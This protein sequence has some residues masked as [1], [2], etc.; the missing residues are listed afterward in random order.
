MP[1]FTAGSMKALTNN[2]YVFYSNAQ[3]T[4]MRIY[5]YDLSILSQRYDLV[6]KVYRPGYSSISYYTFK[7]GEQQLYKMGQRLMIQND[8][9]NAANYYDFVK[10]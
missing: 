9:V 6:N 10:Y 7:E 2:Q 4:F 3:N 5:K 1:C 8:P